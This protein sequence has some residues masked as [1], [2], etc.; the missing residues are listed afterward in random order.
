MIPFNLVF[1]QQARPELILTWISCRIRM[2]G[3][4]TRYLLFTPRYL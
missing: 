3:I 2:P 4:S 1:S